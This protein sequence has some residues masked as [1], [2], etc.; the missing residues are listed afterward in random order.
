MSNDEMIRAICY[1]LMA[2]SFAFYA[3]I[4]YNR[5]RYSLVIVNQ[6]LAIFSVNENIGE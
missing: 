5:R 1:G 4:E 2:P 3:M 6:L